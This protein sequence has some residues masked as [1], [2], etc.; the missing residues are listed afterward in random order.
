M[1]IMS[2]YASA[3]DSRPSRLRQ[4]VWLA[5]FLALCFVAAGVGGALTSTSV[6]SWYQTLVVPAWKPPDW[7][8]G[9][10]WTTLFFMMAVAAWLV[11]RRGG[12]PESRVPL[13]LFAV[14]LG[15]NI[16]WSGIFFGL[17]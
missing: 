2:T 1:T 3:L 5:G 15:L 12:W 16:A 9:P 6:D 13:T 11:W 17:R 10:V 4:T 8:F 14:Q 7:L